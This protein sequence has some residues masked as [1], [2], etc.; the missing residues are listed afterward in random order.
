MIWSSNSDVNMKLIRV[1]S[2]DSV[3]M[4]SVPKIFTTDSTYTSTLGI[5]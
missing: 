4:I 2:D 1:R 3:E 5:Y